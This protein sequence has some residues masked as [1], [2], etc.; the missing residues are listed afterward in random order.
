[1][2]PNH[3]ETLAALFDGEGG[4]PDALADALAQPEA[5]DFLVLL[6]RLRVATQDDN[7]SPDGEF[8]DQANAL[9]DRSRGSWLTARVP[10]AAVAAALL[11]AVALTVATSGLWRPSSPSLP[12]PVP[13]VDAALKVLPAAKTQTVL[14]PAGRPAAGPTRRRPPVPDRV[15]EFVDG[16]DW[17]Q[18][19]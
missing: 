9:F 12:S 10:L 4:G 1:M 19:S 15:L 16:R 8:Y 2:N 13:P 5:A 6:A 11:A 3:E 14:A 17:K 18:G 7:R